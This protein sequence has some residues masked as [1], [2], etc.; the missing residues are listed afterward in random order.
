MVCANKHRQALRA[1]LVLSVHLPAQLNTRY[2]CSQAT[3]YP[4]EVKDV[5]IIRKT[6]SSGI[7]NL[8]VSYDIY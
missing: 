4:R 2:V 7:Q 1:I 6:V 3:R 5:P 8:I